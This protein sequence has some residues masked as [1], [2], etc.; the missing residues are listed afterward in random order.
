ME[1]K[2]NLKISQK[3]DFIVVKENAI[4]EPIRS[5][6]KTPLFSSVVGISR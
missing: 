3:K 6:I 2:L 5:S 1:L 4:K